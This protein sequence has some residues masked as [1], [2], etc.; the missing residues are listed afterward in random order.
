MSMNELTKEQLRR[1]DYVDNVIYRSLVDLLKD[2]TND[3]IKWDIDLIGE[4]RDKYYDTISF[5]TR[6]YNISEDDFYPYM[7]SGRKCKDCNRCL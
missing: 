2:I 6:Y 3:D 5:Y 7:S 1:Q 4:I